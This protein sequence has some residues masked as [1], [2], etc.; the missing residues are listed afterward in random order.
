M[1]GVIVTSLRMT[2]VALGLLGASFAIGE[3]SAAMPVN[4][5]APAENQI[6]ANV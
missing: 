3:A 1:E 2:A 6:S 4:D 5:L